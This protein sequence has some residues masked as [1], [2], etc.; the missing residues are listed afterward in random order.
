M[1]ILENLMPWCTKMKRAGMLKEG[2]KYAKYFQALLK[3]LLSMLQHSYYASS[4]GLG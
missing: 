1:K 4:S 2:C 3:P